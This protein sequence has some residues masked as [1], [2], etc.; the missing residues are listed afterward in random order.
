MAN[1]TL[2]QGETA[3]H[4]AALN[5]RLD[6]LVFD[7]TA[8]EAQLV[9]AAASLI[10]AL[11]ANA[12]KADA[13]SRLPEDNIDALR[14][15]GL[16]RLAT[17]QA[18]GGHQVGARAATAIAAEV[19]R[20]CPSTS[21]V[22]VV[23]YSAAIA[24][25]L[26]P[27]E[28]RHRVWSQDPDATVCG[29]ST[30]AVPVREADG[31][32]VL[33]GRWGWA[34]GAH[35]ATWAI[36][37]VVAQA[38]GPAPDRGVALVPMSELSVE[39]T[40]HMTGMRGTGSDTIRAEEVF[41]PKEQVVLMSQAATAARDNTQALAPVPRPQGLAGA[42]AAPV[43]GMGMAVYDHI[44]AK[45]AEGR[46]LA[47]S[48]KLHARAIDAPG[49]QAN[50]ADAAL[51]IDSAVLHAARSARAVDLATR[52]GAQMSPLAVARIRI[53]AGIAARHIRHAVDKLLDVGGASRFAES[54]P[55]QRIWRDLGTATRHPT[56]ITEIDRE[57]YARILLG[58]NGQ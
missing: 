1:S 31:G 33:T 17:P 46:P 58:F 47:S 39:D 41:V 9:S 50:I 35:H 10:P 25:W 24:L 54:S 57:Q 53:D 28:V 4:S 56:F 32:Y 23:Y 18:Y 51:L 36:L 52:T 55:T 2:G 27:D 12:E 14:N 49:V 3:G 20:G 19:G 43:L 16:L 22:L 44:V 15:A 29:S 42:L 13:T 6:P 30:G 5:D 34:S 38:E 8:E 26:Y 11:S 21:W 45:L 37:D 7:L 40:W 48:V